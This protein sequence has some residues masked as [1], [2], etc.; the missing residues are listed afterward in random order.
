MFEITPSALSDI[1]EPALLP[2]LRLLERSDI[3][4]LVRENA[5]IAV[6][7]LSESPAAAVTLLNDR[8]R[9]SSDPQIA[10][11]LLKSAKIAV[12][13]CR[14]DRQPECQSILF[15]QSKLPASE[16]EK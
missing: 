11:A 7:Q 4:A 16:V 14:V 9:S 8:N 6:V 12:S 10:D 15:D 2:V 5:V 13:K 3:S 1:G